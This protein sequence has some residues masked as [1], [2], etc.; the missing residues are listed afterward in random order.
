[1]DPAKTQSMQISKDI[2][3]P[4]CR[5]LYTVVNGVFF[6]FNIFYPN[7][8]VFFFS[9]LFSIFFKDLNYFLI[10]YFFSVLVV[11][12]RTHRCH[13]NLADIICEIFY[14][15][16]STGTLHYYFFSSTSSPSCQPS[17]SPSHGKYGKLSNKFLV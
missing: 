6:C 5:N 9:K 12:N 10:K 13:V 16:N 7:N 15:T 8:I 1:M 4:F 14:H 17:L 3:I 11:I 2:E